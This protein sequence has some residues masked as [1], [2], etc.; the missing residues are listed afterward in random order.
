M[1]VR[2]DEMKGRWRESGDAGE[3]WFNAKLESAT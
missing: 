3:F 2:G 1:N